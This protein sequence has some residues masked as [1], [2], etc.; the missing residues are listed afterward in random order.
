MVSQS[1][2][3]RYLVQF[4][5]RCPLSP[6]P[7]ASFSLGDRNPREEFLKERIDGATFFDIEEVSDRSSQYP[8]MLPS[9]EQFAEHVGKVSSQGSG[10]WWKFWSPGWDSENR[11]NHSR[12]G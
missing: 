5:A 1:F 7:L 3:R 6:I 11:A 4:T 12:G 2:G 9:A 10:S 8:H